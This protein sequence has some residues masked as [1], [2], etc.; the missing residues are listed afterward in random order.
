MRRPEAIELKA[1]QGR[2]EFRNVSFHYLPE[3]TIL[4][5][6]SFVVEPGKTL[7]ISALN[8]VCQ[9]R[10]VIVVAHRLS[11]IIN[12]DSILVLKDGRVVEQGRH[13]ELIAQEGLYADMW[14]QQLES[15]QGSALATANSSL[16][17][18]DAPSD[19]DAGNKSATANQEQ[20]TRVVRLE[21]ALT[22]LI[23]WNDAWL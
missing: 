16:P 5:D 23:D 4:Q 2:I 18:G 21:A 20:E 19:G 9:G 10:T 14:R 15:N 8:T 11:T 22:E 17:E 3:K 1:P 6:V 7:A 13:N 12:A